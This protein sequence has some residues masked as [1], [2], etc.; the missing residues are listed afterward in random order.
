[1]RRDRGFVLVNAL[2]VVAAVSALSVGVLRDF[3]AGLARLEALRDADRAGLAL[4]AGAVLV[5]RLLN[6]DAATDQRDHLGENWVMQ[7]RSYVLDTQTLTITTEDL[8]G[9]FNLNMLLRPEATAVVVAFVRLAEARGIDPATTDAILEYYA[10][11]RQSRASGPGSADVSFASWE[12][13]LAAELD[14]VN[15]VLALDVLLPAISLLPE[16]AG[17]NLN[18]ARKDVVLALLGDAADAGGWDAFEAARIAQPMS[19]IEEA[20][21]SVSV[22]F[23]QAVAAGLDRKSVTTFSDWFEVR[24]RV[25]QEDG[26]SAATFLLHRSGSPAVTELIARIPV[27]G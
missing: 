13:V 19:S 7:D 1:M 6:N 5:T 25:R 17:V 8:Q 24:A 18:T 26:S 3:G 11:L 15:G 12:P 10:D 22:H 4:D 9:R 23:G 20:L 2:V 16:P 21:G 14:A 27:D